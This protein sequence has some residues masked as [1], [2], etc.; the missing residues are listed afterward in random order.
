MITGMFANEL[1]SIQPL[2]ISGVLIYKLILI[3]IRFA[4]LMLHRL[5][6]QIVHKSIF[7]PILKVILQLIHMVVHGINEMMMGMEFSIHMIPA[8]TLLTQKFHRMDV[9]VGNGTLTM[10][11]LS[12]FL[13][14]VQKLQ[15]MNSQIR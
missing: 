3:L 11:E 8:Q 14:S 15:R 5:V 13:M 2:I 6:L 9:Q 7:A 12:I 10:M 1:K 4:T